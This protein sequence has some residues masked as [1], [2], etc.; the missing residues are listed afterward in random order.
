TSG[1]AQE[2]VTG[3]PVVYTAE[4]Q[5]RIKLFSN[6]AKIAAEA[7]RKEF[8]GLKILIPWGDPG[9]SWP[10]LRAGLT[11]E[12]I[13]GSGIDI[14]GF[15]RIP[16]RQLHE[17]SIHRLYF[18]KPEFAKAGIPN[19]QL[20][21]CEG[22]FVP[23]EPGAVSW[24]E[25]MDIYQ[26]WALI[27]MAHG[28]KRF[29][30]AWFAFD[31]GSYYGAEHYGGCGIQRRIPYCDPKPAYAAYATMTD[32]LNDADF[33]G[34]VKTGS[35]TTFCLRFKHATRGNIYALWT[36]RGKR[37]VTLTLASDAEVGVTDS[38]NNEIKIKSKSR[39]V[40]ITTD[41]SV[42]YLTNAGE[43]ASAAAGEPDHSDMVP[44]QDARRVADLGDGS[45]KYTSRRDEIYE[46]NHWGISPAA[47]KFSAATA[48]DPVKGRVLV[49]KLEKQEKV[50]ELMPWYN[51]LK[52]ERPIRLDGAPFHIGLWVKG[53]SDWGRVI[54]ILRDNKGERWTSIG[55]K[56]DYNSDDVHSWSSFNFDGWR[57]LRF[58]L[59]GHLGWDNF[60]RHGTTW[61]GSHGGDK[62]VDLPLKLEE[63]I[64]EQR[65]HI[66][67]VNDIQPVASDAVSLG[68]LH[69]EYDSPEDAKEEAVRLSRLRMPLPQGEVD[70]PNPIVALTKDGVGAPTEITRLQPPE[71]GADG[72]RIHVHFKEVEGAKSY[73]IWVS[74]HKDG[75][76]AA[77]MTPSGIQNGALIYGLRPAMKLYYWVAWQDAK[78]QMSKPSPVHEE[79]LAD[80][81][82]EK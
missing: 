26:R 35:L 50:R 54:Y 68:T 10:L 31:C 19:P 46:K 55:T 18:M 20:Q 82:K 14:P 13:D 75:R 39:S 78:G 2:Y 9:F 69:V 36:L 12:V 62:I 28:V 56:D 47:G 72:T 67:Y 71:H 23:T 43:I 80:M 59:P 6:T 63:I 60:R 74:A 37:P 66:L 61:W 15:E 34:W 73:F 24:R 81:F 52:P 57:Y 41:P 49:S 22:I 42:I 44:A 29:Y 76:G 70:L 65:S 5:Q 16:E 33:D 27:S 64:V 1:N 58:E 79:V 51:V 53:A 32:K 3:E 4:E 38:M 8:P 40:E 21:F 30:S 11:K 25:Q 7:V 45:W 17:Q 48:D 77:N